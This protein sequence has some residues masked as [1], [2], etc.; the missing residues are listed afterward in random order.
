MEPRD[1]RQ[2]YDDRRGSLDVETGGAKR[3]YRCHSKQ[4]VP[5]QCTL[6]FVNTTGSITLY[7]ASRVEIRAQVMQDWYR[8]KKQQSFCTDSAARGADSSSP[9]AVAATRRIDLS[10]GPAAFSPDHYPYRVDPK[11]DPE[12][13]SFRAWSKNVI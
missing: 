12:I 1:T 4:D 8:R 2:T 10:L 6:R 13:L 7:E 5:T 3:A 11:S 9:S